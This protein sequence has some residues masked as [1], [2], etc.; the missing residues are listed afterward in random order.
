MNWALSSLQGGS[1]KI[2][3][4]VPLNNKYVNVFNLRKFEQLKQDLIKEQEEEKR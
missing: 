1:I 4:K 2:S 3:L